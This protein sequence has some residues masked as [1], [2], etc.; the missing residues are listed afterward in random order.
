MARKTKRVDLNLLCE[1]LAQELGYELVEAAFEKEGAGTY[2]RIYLDR[3]GGISLSDCEA[4]HR[5]LQPLVED[6]DY[7]FLEV[8]SPGIDRP[9]KTRAQ[10]DKVKGRQVEIRLY[11]PVDGK[12]Q[13]TGIFQGLDEAGYHLKTGE[14]Q[15]VF[16][17][18]DVAVARLSINVDETLREH[19]SS[20]QE[21]ENE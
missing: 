7:D 16:P 12:R 1:R 14:E 2:L 6:V 18:K 9:I 19:E 13:W 20:A 5:K 3:E 4:Y 11:R 8:C 10:A 17:L 15:L 21:E